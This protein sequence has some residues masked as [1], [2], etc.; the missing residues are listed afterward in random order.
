MVPLY[1]LTK[2]AYMYGAYYRNRTNN[3]SLTRRLL[4][5]IELSRHLTGWSIALRFAYCH[6]PSLRFRDVER[7]SR[8]SISKVVTPLPLSTFNQGFLC[9]RTL[10]IILMAGRQELESRLIG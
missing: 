10:S 6:V 7:F 4:C 3:L 8:L 2:E 5:R 1:H 9:G